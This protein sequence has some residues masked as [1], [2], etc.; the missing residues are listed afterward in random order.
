M[1]SSR[2]ANSALETTRSGTC[3]PKREGKRSSA[4][5]D[6]GFHAGDGIELAGI[7]IRVGNLDGK[8]FFDRAHHIGEGE[9][10]QQTALEKR[11]FGVVRQGL[12]GDL[13]DH[14]AEALRMVSGMHI[15]SLP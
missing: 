6:V 11:F 2:A 4:A 15:S 8:L 14:A 12:L 10:I 3:A 9:G 7:Q 13:L 1:Q 5:G